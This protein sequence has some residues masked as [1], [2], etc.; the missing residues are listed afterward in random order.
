M[1]AT[2]FSNMQL[3]NSRKSEKKEEE[4]DMKLSYEQA[5]HL[6]FSP[7]SSKREQLSEQWSP[8]ENWFPLP[9]Y[10]EENDCI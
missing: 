8:V 9:L 3:S 2:T 7:L 10:I 1:P 4:A 6:L 5:V